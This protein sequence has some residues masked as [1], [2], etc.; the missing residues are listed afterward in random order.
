MTTSQQDKLVIE[1]IGKAHTPYPEKFAIPRQPGI[2]TA[3]QGYIELFDQQHARQM[4]NGIEQYS[5]LWV[6]FGFHAT[7][8]QGWK[9]MVRPPRLGGNKKMGVLA[10]RSTFRPNPIG[11]SVVKFLKTDNINNKTV[12]RIQGMDLLDQ[13]PI[14]DIKPYIPYSDAVTDATSD[15]A[16][17]VSTPIQV[18]FNDQAQ[19]QLSLFD[20][21]YPDLSLLIEQVLSQDPRPAYKTNQVDN[22]V[23]G[24]ALFD[25]NIQWQ[26]TNM[27]HAVVINMTKS[28][29]EN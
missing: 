10:T 8:K 11:M 27:N 23:Y 18:S 24:M 5:H 26:M 16:Q 20:K 9:P 25:L 7:Q 3:A 6:L 28:T 15:F 4:L 21:H 29:H 13:T 1:Y 2:V 12:I 14:I 22:N 19:S 17:S